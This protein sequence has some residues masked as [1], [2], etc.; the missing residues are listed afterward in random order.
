VK[1]MFL[2]VYRY[3]L[4]EKV[5]AVLSNLGVKAFS[6]APKVLGVGEA[7][8]VQDTHVFPGYNACVFA[9]LPEADVGRLVDA[10]REFSRKHEEEFGK[11]APLRAFVLPCEQVV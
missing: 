5:Q 11:A 4:E 1:K 6:E 3:Y 8:K 2:V 9:V 7:G 10:F